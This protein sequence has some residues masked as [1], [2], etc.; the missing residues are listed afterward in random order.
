MLL[1]IEQVHLGKMNKYRDG[2]V[3]KTRYVKNLVCQ[4][5]TFSLI[6]D[7]TKNYNNFLDNPK[8]S[9]ML[10]VFW[11]MLKNQTI[12]KVLDIPMARTGSSY[13]KFLH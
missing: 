11:S 9:K 1:G 2:L 10:K 12:K 3:R 13:R 4:N 7:Q 8:M 6:F 5:G